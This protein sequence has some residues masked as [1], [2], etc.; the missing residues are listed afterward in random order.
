MVFLGP[1]ENAEFLPKLHV[2][3]YG[4][5]AALPMLSSIVRTNTVLPTSRTKLWSKAVHLLSSTQNIV[6][7]N[8]LPTSLPNSLPFL[9]RLGIFLGGKERPARRA[10]NLTTICEPIV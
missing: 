8:A 10:D 7:F 6:Q 5:L 2:A 3:L 9:E 1:T 4:S